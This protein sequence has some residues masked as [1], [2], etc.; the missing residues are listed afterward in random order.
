MMKQYTRTLQLRT[1]DCDVNGLWRFSSILETMQEAAG[2]HCSALGCG[3]TELAKRGLAWVIVR[4]EIRMEQLPSFE[5]TVTVTTFHK[6]VRHRFFPRYFIIRNEANETIGM[7]STL[8]MLINLQTRQTADPT[9]VVSLMPDNSDLDAPMPFPAH[10]PDC[11][12]ESTVINRMVQYTDLDMTGHVNNAR[13]ADWFCNALG[14]D[15]LR[16]EMIS[17]MILNY[18]TEILEGQTVTLTLTRN[19]DKS[20]MTG[21]VEGK[22][23]FE[24]GCTLQKV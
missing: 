14:L 19:N 17:S 10:I 1:K 16:N 4:N 21:T 15:I 8:W 24:I 7:A 13:Y 5:E 22:N 20:A 18:N 23:A 9:Y 3:R 12:G 6:A 11:D 2:D